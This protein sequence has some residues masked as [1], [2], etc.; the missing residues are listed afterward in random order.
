MVIFH[1]YVSLPEGNQHS[2]GDLTLNQ[3]EYT[4]QKWEVI[5]GS[6]EPQK[7]IIL[8]KSPEMRTVLCEATRAP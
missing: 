4:Q 7:F 5:R 8:P 6:M 3:R 1:S 2:Y